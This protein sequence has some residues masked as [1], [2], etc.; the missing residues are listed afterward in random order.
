MIKHAGISVK[1]FRY[2]LKS[3][4]CFLFL[5]SKYSFTSFFSVSKNE[6]SALLKVTFFNFNRVFIRFVTAKVGENLFRKVQVS[7]IC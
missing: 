1:V 6:L 3:P 5:D 2:N 4:V 7:L